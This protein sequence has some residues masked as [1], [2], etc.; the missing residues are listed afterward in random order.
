M[1]V[2]GVIADTHIPDRKAFLHPEVLPIFQKAGVSM[3]LH[4]GDVSTPKVLQQLNQIAPVHTV[5]GNRDF[6][7]RKNLPKTLELEIEG[8]KIG[9]AHGYENLKHYLFAKLINPIDGPG[10][11]YYQPYLAKEFSKMQVIVFGHIHRPI[12]QWINGQLYFNPGSASVPKV[13]IPP[14]IGLLHVQKG[15]ICAE[16]IRLAHFSKKITL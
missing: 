8:W 1:T 7:Q 12:N 4:A 5:R 16:H 13:P 6:F 15:E 10:F 14:S 11:E 9:V 3:I 2:L